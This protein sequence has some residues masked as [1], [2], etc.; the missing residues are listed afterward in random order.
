M[1]RKQLLTILAAVAVLL[2]FSVS[3]AAEKEIFESGDH[4]VAYKA[5]KKMFFSMNVEV[6]GKNCSA[7]AALEWSAN[8]KSAVIKV[9]IPVDKFDSK[10][11]GPR[12]EHVAEILGGKGLTPMIFTS[13]SIDRETFEALAKDGK[14]DIQ[15]T[16][17]ID[18]KDKD[19]TFSVWVTGSGN[20][21]VVQ[22]SLSTSFTTLNVVVPP[23]GPGGMMAN[24][25]DALELHAHLLL[26]RISGIEALNMQ[27]ATG[28]A[29]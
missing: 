13:A 20:G 17:K 25:D 15:G 29:R 21:K 12:D 9:V 19:V 28:N 16:L 3:D 22:A 23:A 7:D 8:S 2:P 1:L 14:T 5:G 11:I 26:E 27:T 6:I 18:G 10:S 4:C 24:P